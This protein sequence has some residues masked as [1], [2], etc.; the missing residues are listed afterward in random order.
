MLLLMIWSHCDLDS[1]IYRFTTH[2]KT[3]VSI[4]YKG[5]MQQH[6]S[7]AESSSRLVN[8]HSLTPCITNL[9]AYSWSWG[10]GIVTGGGGWLVILHPKSGNSEHRLDP[11]Y[12]IS[13]SVLVSHFLQQGSTTFLNSTTKEDSIQS[14]EP[15][16]NISHYIQ[17]TPYCECILFMSLKPLFWPT[18]FRMD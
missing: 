13:W 7:M 2:L 6:G 10:T 1:E 12:D 16:W 17:N 11:D 9:R 5:T 8:A 3:T 18:T 15:I 4:V 14:H